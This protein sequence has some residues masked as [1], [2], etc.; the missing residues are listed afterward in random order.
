MLK[1]Q[2]TQAEYDEKRNE[3]FITQIKIGKVRHLTD[4]T[5]DL[6]AKKRQHL[7]LT[8][9]NGSGKTSVL[10]GIRDIL[11]DITRGN[12]GRAGNKNK[13]AN[14]TVGHK[15][16]PIHG[17]DEDDTDISLTYN[18][19]TEV[20]EKYRSGEFITSFFSA[21]RPI[22]DI[23]LPSGVE[24]VKLKHLYTMSDDPAKNIAKYMVHLNAQQLYAEK[25]GDNQ[26]AENIKAWFD[27]FEKA[28]RILM[29]DASVSLKYDY[30]KYNFMIQQ[31]K[32]N[33]VN[34][35]QLSHGYASVF[36][37]FADLLMR[38]EQN[39][40][41]TSQLSEY[42][43][44]GVVL[45]DELETHLHLEM[46]KKVLPSLTTLFPRLQFIISTHSPFVLSSLENVVI[47]DLENGTLVRQPQ[48]LTDIPYEGIVE[49]YFGADS[50]SDKLREKYE[51]F[52]ELVKKEN[53]NDDELQEIS[54][55][56]LF[57]DEIPDYLALNITTEY[58]RLK[59]EF[60]AQEV[61]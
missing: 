60:Y 47:Y 15:K 28:L 44:E 56:E 36:R 10:S 32:H 37:I 13:V 49:G 6:N 17:I 58:R 18:L 51:R 42:D 40:A 53:L 25:E 46:Q 21:V 39:W 22:H 41:S 20:Y 5:I 31:D 9:K 50:L 38:M 55:L 33:P 4:I 8:G 61:E 11:L 14:L 1:T 34:F 23:L 27:R 54:S 16:I 52:K 3:H 45:I 35:N 2:L 12:H 43:K 29:N 26:T 30:K 19:G 59:S 7:I 24:N 57:L 48:G